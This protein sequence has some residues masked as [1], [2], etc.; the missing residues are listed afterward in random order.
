MSYFNHAFR[1]TFIGTTL[2]GGGGYTGLNGGQLGTTGNIFPG[3]SFGF[4][5]PKTWTVVPTTYSA[6]TIGC[7]NLILAA[8]SIYQNDKIGP[9]HGGYQESNKS[10]EINPKYVNKFYRV[11]PCLP[12][13]N[14]IHIGNTAYTDDVA[15]SL[16]ITN[17]GANIANGVYNNIPLVDLSSPT[18]SG[19]LADI[20]VVGGVVTFVEIAN[21]GSGWVDGDIVQPETGIS[22][23]GSSISGTTM[24]IAAMAANGGSFQPGMVIQGTGVT[25]GTTILSQ[26]TGT[27]GGAGT[28]EV[29][30]SQT[31]AGP[32]TITGFY[33]PWDGSGSITSPTFTVDAGIGANCCKKFYCG[34]TYTL[35]VDVKGS[36]A[37]RLLNHNSYIIASAY[38]GCCPDGAIAPVEIDSTLIFIQWAE[39]I[40]RY[41]VISPFMQIVVV[42]QSGAPLYAPG[43]SAA[44]LATVPGSKTWDQYVSPGYIL[45]DCAGMVLNGAYVDTKFQNCTFQIS[46]FYEV[47]PV[48]LYASEV[49]LNG[50]PCLFDGVCVITECEGRQ[51]MG[52]GESVARDVILSEQYRQNFFSS[53]FRIREITQG[54]SVFDY[55]NRNTLYT[56]YFLQHNVPRF[57]NPSSTFDNDQYL[58]EVITCGPEAAFETFV[59]AWLSNC[60]DCV[61]LELEGCVKPAC[62]PLYEF[63]AVTTN[64]S[65]NQPTICV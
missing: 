45:N 26:L 33:L 50:D 13:N 11:D 60:S 57:N 27:T 29:S 43:T 42:D 52:L 2:A 49:D 30:I 5:N 54:Y 21:G 61:G 31:V 40:T 41:P 24:T 25:A 51:V 17:A 22:S 9:F 4:V 36:P 15:L 18:G 3:G 47:E 16:A 7:C 6:T 58:L 64:F 56:R 44:F 10:K 62:V 1:K 35:R 38:G 65:P 8:G 20:T 37:L 63:P 59:N 23:A 28:Y 55:I 53:D 12:Q 14:I 39:A 19:L 32:I 34:E 46:D 48:R